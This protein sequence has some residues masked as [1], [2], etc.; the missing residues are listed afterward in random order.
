MAAVKIV[1][2]GRN[3]STALGVIRALG[4]KN[5]E[6]DLIFISKGD[7]DINIIKA[8][9]YIN[10]CY[11]VLGR[12]AE[13]VVELLQ[14]EYASASNKIVLFPTDDYTTSVIFKYRDIL[15]SKF[16]FPDFGCVPLGEK[17]PLFMSKVRQHTLAIENG[18]STA[19]QYNLEL[20]N[21]KELDKQLEEA[22]ERKEIVLPCFVKPRDGVSGNKSELRKCSNI[23][24][25]KQH[26][27]KMRK[28]NPHRGVLIEE[29]LD[30]EK[31]IIATGL[32]L[33]EKIVLPAVVERIVVA[34][35]HPGLTVYGK[36]LS[37][38]CI[39]EIEDKIYSLLKCYDCV[40]MFGMD[41]LVC[42]DGRIVAAEINFRSS[43]VNYA[44]TK[45]GV[46]LPVMLVEYLL[47]GKEPKPDLKGLDYG[48]EFFNDK[49]AWT[50]CLEGD[51]SQD[52]LESL[53]Q[54]ASFRI[55]EADEDMEPYRQFVAAMQLK[56]KKKKRKKLIKSL[57]PFYLLKNIFKS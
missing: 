12:N 16:L 44:L 45:W 10:R 57:N 13:D 55:M 50:E 53:E 24:E 18:L 29:F 37:P 39:K 30:I 14:K 8:S 23:Q 20:E 4:E 51:L 26:L 41:L 6:P 28:S 49:V 52:K 46:N 32:C 38:T 19:L 21:Y 54:Q 22:I 47:H 11:E 31:E 17:E 42:R 3:Y 33:K 48:I 43:G 7:G 36:L 25:L 9:K 35:K 34:K 2:L 56:D 1:V 15:R 40:T 5:Y 27:A